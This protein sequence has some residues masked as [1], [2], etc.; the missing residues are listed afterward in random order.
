MDTSAV[1]F[2]R[3]WY[4]KSALLSLI[5]FFSLCLT[6]C[7][8]FQSAPTIA[9]KEPQRPAVS[10]EPQVASSSAPLPE[11]PSPTVE[12]ASKPAEVQTAPAAPV[13]VAESKPATGA[14]PLKGG[15]TLVALS[16]PAQPR[17]SEPAAS[18]PKPAVSTAPKNEKAASA[19]LTSE[20]PQALIFK[21]PAH[22]EAL[23]SHKV[24]WLGL[25]LGL[26]AAAG[27]GITWVR[28]N[29][30]RKP[31]EIFP[32]NREEICLPKELMVKECTI[33]VEEPALPESKPVLIIKK[34]VVAQTKP[35]LVEKEPKVA[36]K[37]P[38]LAGNA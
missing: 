30:S 10:P 2:C 9:T 28:F 22:Q 11:K 26:C 17:A 21:G 35:E 25:G 20:V 6:G 29:R 14:A 34:P 24:L 16:A 1:A 3:T 5:F 31:Q 32:D 8:T 36:E 12:K 4:R 23:V 15:G 19:P 18:V 33:P 13:H 38:I 27:G 37:K 7:D